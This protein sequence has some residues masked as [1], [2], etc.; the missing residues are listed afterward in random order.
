MQYVRDSFSFNEFTNQAKSILQSTVKQE[1][2]NAFTPK[3]AQQLKVN[4]TRIII[5][6]S[7]FLA[8][9]LIGAIVSLITFNSI[10]MIVFT[11]ISAIALIVTTVFLIS[12]RKTA[13]YLSK[14]I[15]RNLNS[16]EIYNKILQIIDQAFHYHGNS[17]TYADNNLD[18]NSVD[19]NIKEHDW[20]RP[21][22]VESTAKIIRTSKKSYFDI[23]N[24]YPICSQNVIWEYVYR[25]KDREEKKH[26]YATLLKI[27]T[28]KSKSKNFNFGMFSRNCVNGKKIKLENN[29]F[30]K[31][32]QLYSDNELEARKMYTPLAME[33]T[34]KHYAQNRKNQASFNL[35]IVSH[36]DTV[37]ASFLT[38]DSGFLNIDVP[39]SSKKEKIESKILKDIIVDVFTYYYIIAYLF[40][41]LYLD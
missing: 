2:A 6:L 8:S 33:N 12:Y 11:A 23:D 41:P 15:Q 27:D 19:I 24:K 16:V 32:M 5:S 13:N 38:P 18:F 36:N 31:I 40:I 39:M 21:S 1:V 20:Y 28:S 3:I 10:A 14:Q 26:Y 37:Y 25:T 7:V 30:N 17:I 34:V 9:F 29:E 4:K 22:T 35:G